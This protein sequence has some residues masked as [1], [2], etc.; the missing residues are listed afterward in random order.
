MDNSTSVVNLLARKASANIY[1][2]TAKGNNIYILCG[3]LLTTV[4]FLGQ[5]P[6]GYTDYVS[7]HDIN[8]TSFTK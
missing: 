1:I 4:S 5:C 7:R 3:N 2:L 8:K 6:G